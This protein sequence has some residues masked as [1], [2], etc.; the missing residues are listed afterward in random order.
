MMASALLLTSSSDVAQPQTLIRM[1]GVG[2]VSKTLA[3]GVRL[4]WVSAPPTWLT[5]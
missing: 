1:A 3:P 4:G 5:S 2:T